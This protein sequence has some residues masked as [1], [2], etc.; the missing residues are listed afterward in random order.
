M[1]NNLKPCPFCGGNA[2]ILDGDLWGQYVICNSCEAS[3]GVM[4]GMYEI[5]GHFDGH[6]DAAR[7][8]NI[9][10]KEKDQ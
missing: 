10:T 3:L 1:S 8:W 5:N 6:G 4:D 9:R 7:A 2:S